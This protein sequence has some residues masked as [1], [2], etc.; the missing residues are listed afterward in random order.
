MK[1][2]NIKLCQ[3]RLDYK[4]PLVFL[5]DSKASARENCEEMRGDARR[6]RIARTRVVRS[7][8]H[9]YEKYGITRIPRHGR[10]KRIGDVRKIGEEVGWASLQLEIFPYET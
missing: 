9:P 10:G 8:C 6:G 3:T 4:Q 1:K 5:R 7:L 2:A